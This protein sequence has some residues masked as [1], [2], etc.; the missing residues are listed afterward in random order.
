MKDNF[1]GWKDQADVHIPKVEKKG[2]SDQVII[3]KPVEPIRM[4]RPEEYTGDEPTVLL[5]PEMKIAAYI[6]R[7]KTGEEMEL[8]KDGFVIGKSTE[9]D[10]IIKDNPTISRKHA[11]I[12]HGEDGYW[13][14]DMGS[15]NHTFI[16]G[17]QLTGEVHLTNHM[18]FR[19][20]QDEE[21]EFTVRAEH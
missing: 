5:Y 3:R 1:E 7:L 16:D 15:A 20:S 10:F 17:Q 14:E 18:V 6:K 12:R 4:Q 8:P 21:F 11:K 2:F 19:L 13:L 9:A